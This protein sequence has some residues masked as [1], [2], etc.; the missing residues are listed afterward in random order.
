MASCY[1][2][3]ILCGSN[4]SPLQA[5][6]K[7]GHTFQ[8]RDGGNGKLF[9]LSDQSPGSHRVSPVASPI[10]P[11]PRPRLAVRRSRAPPRNEMGFIYCDHVGCQDNPPVFRRPCEWNK[12]MDKHDRPYKCNDQECAK[13]PGFT[14]SGGLLRH[15]REVHRMHS[16]GKKLMCPFA[17]CNRSSG[18]GF[19]RH[20][21]LKEHLRRLH[22]ADEQQP[23]HQEITPMDIVNT[24]PNPPTYNKASISQIISNTDV[25]LPSMSGP[26]PPA[27]RR[28]TL[29]SPMPNSPLSPPLLPS[30]TRKRLYSESSAHGSE[31]ETNEICDLRDEVFRLRS[32]IQSKDTRL[33]ELER[34]VKGLQRAAQDH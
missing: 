21:N 13:L 15:Q 31:G 33:D 30:T 12:H 22:K 25:V 34:I 4:A 29:H 26:T 14:Y 6:E 7:F 5:M 20:E 27:S 19:S 3:Y 11:H 24:N 17:D 9:P 28:P 16:Q 10:T 8:R 1:I 2:H 32:E 18:R 23:R